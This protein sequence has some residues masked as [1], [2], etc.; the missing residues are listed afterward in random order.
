MH[1]A[2]S[3]GAFLGTF[4]ELSSSEIG[5]EPANV[6]TARASL[7]GPD[8]ESGDAV[9]ALYRRTLAELARVPGVEA[10]A[11]ASNLP[12]ERGLRIPCARLRAARS[13]GTSTGAT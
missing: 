6:L 8:Y 13:G 2:A 10:A 11:V 7:Q 1:D 5:F 4:V 12:V 9:S 3:G